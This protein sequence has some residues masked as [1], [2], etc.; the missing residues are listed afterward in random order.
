MW[1]LATSKNNISIAELC[2]LG[3]ESDNVKESFTLTYFMP[4]INNYTGEL[5]EITSEKI[6]LISLTPLLVNT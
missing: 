5:T 1:E 6:T 4:T 3:E 2:R